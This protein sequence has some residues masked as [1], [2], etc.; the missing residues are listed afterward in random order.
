MNNNYV[1]LMGVG[2]SMETRQSVT[3]WV[4]KRSF[5]AWRIYV[6]APNSLPKTLLMLTLAYSFVS[7]ISKRGVQLCALN[8]MFLRH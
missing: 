2:G 6:M 7:L 8:L 4:K 1:A 3:G 5:S